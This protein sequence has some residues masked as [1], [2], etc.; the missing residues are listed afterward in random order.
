M[1]AMSLKIEGYVS[2]SPFTFERRRLRSTN[3]IGWQPIRFCNSKLNIRRQRGLQRGIRLPKSF[4]LVASSKASSSSSDSSGGSSYEVFLSFNGKD[5]RTNFADHLYNGLVGS[6]IRTFRDDDELQKGKEIGPD[7]VSAIQE[8]RFSIPIFSMN[9]GSSKWCLNELLEICECRRTMKQIV[10]PIFYKVEPRD[11]RNQTGVYEKFFEEHQK[12]FDDTTVQKWKNA[13]KEVGKLD[14]WHIKEKTHEGKLIKVV[15]KTVWS[16]LNKRPLNVSNN[17]VGIES[18]IEKMLM[19]LNI[20]SG[21]RKIV[22]IH[23]LGGVGKTT[24]ARAVYNTIFHHFEGYSFIE[25]IQENAQNYGLPHLQNQLIFDILKQKNHNITSVDD[26]MD[27]LQQRFRDKKVLI[28]LDDVDQDTHVRCLV[29]NHEWFGIGSKI[30]ITSRNEDVLCAHEVDEMYKPN[31]MDLDHSLQLFS[32]HAFRR[33]QPPEDYLDFSKA[34]V[35]TTGGLPL[36]L[37]VIGSS[38]FSREKSVWEDMLKKLQKIPNNDI[39]KRLKISYDRL[40]DEEQQIF[41]DAACFFVGMNKEI[42]C[43]IWDGCDFFPQVGLRAL[44]ARSLITISEDGELRMHDLLRDLGREIVRQESIKEPGKRTRI[45][46]QEEVLDVLDTQTGTS[47]VEGLSLAFPSRSSSPCLSDKGFVPMT[48]LRLLQFDHAKFL[49]SITHSLSEL[50]W[51]SWK[52][53]HDQYVQTNFHPWKLA[54]LDLSH[55]DITKEWM[56]WNCIK[57]AVNLKVLILTSCHRLTTTP[58]LSANRQLEVLILKDCENL[59]EIDASIGYLENLVKLDMSGCKS[60]VDLPIEILQLTSLEEL[61]LEG[62]KSLNKLPEE[63]GRM[64]SLTTLDLSGCDR[65][66]SLPNLPLSLKIF[67]ASNCKSIRSLP[68]LSSLENLK[69]LSFRGCLKLLYIPNL[70]LSLTS[71]DVRSCSSI[72]NISGLPSSLICLDVYGC[73]SIQHIP[74]LP[75]SLTRLDVSHCSSIQHISISGLPSSLTHLHVS[76]C[77]SVKKISGLPSSL[78]HLHVSDCPSVK[79]IS[80]LFSSLTHLHVSD[81]SSIQYIPGLPS[82]LISLH[83]IAC[84][85]I[86]KLSSTSGLRNLETLCLDWCYSLE[87]I[88]GVDIKGLDSLVFFT[89]R[90]SKSLK[91]FQK[92]TGWKKLRKLELTDCRISDIDG[93]G[94]DS[95]EELDIADCRPLRKISDL[96]DSRQ[97]R[98]LRINSCPDLF[99]IEGLEDCEYLRTLTVSGASSLKTL[100]DLSKLM[101]LQVLRIKSCQKLTEIPGLDKLESLQELKIEGCIAI[102][103]LP[104]LSNFKN[105]HD[106]VI[107][108]GRKLTK[109]PGL[110]RLESLRELKIEGCVAIQRLPDLS[111]L[112]NLHDLAIEDCQKLTEIHG[113]DRLHFLKSLNINGCKSLERLPDLSNLKKLKLLSAKFCKKLTEIRAVNGLKSLNLLDV[114]GCTYLEKLPDLKLL[115]ALS[116]ENGS[117]RIC[118][119]PLRTGYIGSNLLRRGALF[120]LSIFVPLFLSRHYKCDLIRRGTLFILGTAFTILFTWI[121]LHHR[122]HQYCKHHLSFL[123]YD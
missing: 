103:R 84:E 85:S 33:D 23:G 27:V 20:E 102:Q 5:I 32:H 115:E 87:E 76:D 56:V 17:L 8:S 59:V 47:N 3:L 57:M 78:T 110:D 69:V 13:L 91:I 45:W 62:C 117:V 77:P 52:G 30:I 75:S 24:I 46:S 7:L 72:R 58:D 43:H 73:S 112:K 114:R 94:M 54:V 22:G 40:D 109:I 9:Y 82:S 93:K 105:L 123:L 19:L 12:R 121:W 16:E 90:G 86:K 50:R 37:Q 11:V 2:S 89:M 120:I 66:G 67:D 113:L 68:M 97:L 53:F 44:C 92:L 61:N 18:H 35:E 106:L 119:T 63:L 64:I 6:G 34:M 104:D 60:L 55:S 21:S 65:L 29:G 111:N 98:K 26:G 101:K 38:L 49:G 51:L 79:K 48:K 88:E 4:C 14:G 95:L 83:V 116:K 42:A 118:R 15:V 31:V 81:C 25:N 96:S 36:A 39:M 122:F 71:L 99:K 10:F 74:D 80:G 28:V 1:A 100:P 70:P 107:K 108:H 41:L